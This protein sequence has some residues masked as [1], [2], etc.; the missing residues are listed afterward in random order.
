MSKALSLVVEAEVTPSRFGEIGRPAGAHARNDGPHQDHDVSGVD[1]T[2]I[3]ACARETPLDCFR[4]R[5]RFAS[6]SASAWW[7]AS[8][9]RARSTGAERPRSAHALPRAG[10]AHRSTV[11]VQFRTSTTWDDWFSMWVVQS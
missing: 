7:S 10:R 11:V 3:R 8:A 4:F 2:L 9:R 6:A 5:F 1:R